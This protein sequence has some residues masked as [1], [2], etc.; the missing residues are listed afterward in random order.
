MATTGA[1]RK[2]TLKERLLDGEITIGPAS[3]SSC[4]SVV[5]MIGYCGFD[6]VFID[7]EQAGANIGLELEGLVRAAHVAEI[8]AIVRIPESG[9]S[10]I[11]KTLNTGAQGIWVPHVESAEEAK[12]CV[13]A[14]LYPPAGRRGAAPVIR[15]AEH[16]FYEWDT[17]MARAN[18]GNLITLTIETVKGL[19]NVEEIAAVP[20]VDSLCMGPF[21]MA[22]DMGLPSSA[23]YGD[24]TVTWVHERLEDAARRT[25]KACEDNG[26]IPATLAWNS[27][28]LERWIN[29]GFRNLLFGTDVSLVH[30]A[31][32]G[33]KDQVDDIKGRVSA[34]A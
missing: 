26:L 10:I 34:V 24:G 14:A 20:G 1:L 30:R 3:V 17:Y 25:L 33:L 31:L 22:V 11:N 13:D 9:L 21:D 4:P 27:D 23:H 19:E 2:R 18:E 32:L 28:S 6:W 7:T 5:E 16:A 8:P 15:A 29:M 12:L